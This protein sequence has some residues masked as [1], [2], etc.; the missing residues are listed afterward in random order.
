MRILS[1]VFLF[2]TFIASAQPQDNSAR[3]MIITPVSVIP[4]DTEKVLDNQAV[5]VKNGMITY[6]GDAKNA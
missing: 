4:M 5:I 2:I 3:E 1:L 6:L